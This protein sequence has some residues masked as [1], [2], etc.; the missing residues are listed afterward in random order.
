M[1]CKLIL[2]KAASKPSPETVKVLRYL[3]GEAEAGRVTG[4]AFVALH[5][6]N[7]YSTGVIGHS[8]EIPTITRGMVKMLDDEVAE[9][10]HP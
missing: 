3:L 6:G 5:Q 8:R 1:A 7:D 2:L 10:L 4:L 9:L